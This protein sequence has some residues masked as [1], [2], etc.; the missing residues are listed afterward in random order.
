MQYKNASK[1]RGKLFCEMK[2]QFSYDGKLWITENNTK[3]FEC[4]SE[5][6]IAMNKLKLCIVSNFEVDSGVSNQPGV[7]K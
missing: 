1:I 5:I 6:F 3:Y 4:L 7:W 2:D